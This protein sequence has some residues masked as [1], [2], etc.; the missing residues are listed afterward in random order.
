MDMDSITS[1]LLEGRYDMYANA[2]SYFTYHLREYDI[3]YNPELQMVK[4]TRDSLAVLRS[5]Y[6]RESGPSNEED[7][8]T[9]N[10]IRSRVLPKGLPGD[11]P[12]RHSKELPKMVKTETKYHVDLYDTVT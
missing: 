3:D 9:Y 4:E 10:L 7:S 1:E 8:I 2:K 5:Q 12:P 11:I 6:N